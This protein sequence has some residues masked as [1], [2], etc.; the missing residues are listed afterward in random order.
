MGGVEGPKTAYTGRVKRIGLAL[1]ISAVMLITASPASA[2]PEPSLGC[3]PTSDTP[4]RTG[5][6]TP[7]E[8]PLADIILFQPL[9][10]GGIQIFAAT[11]EVNG[12]G[13]T[14][15]PAGVA[16]GSYLVA[17]SARATFTVLGTV[18]IGGCLPTGK[19]QCT[20]G[21]WRAFDFMN[22]G[23]CVAFVNRGAKA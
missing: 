5:I 4:F 8:D 16:P 23:R 21:G 1:V 10:G 12:E 9:P 18:Q 6:S 7:I 22:Q 13:L 14:I 2:Q 3:I 11:D 20:K 17:F 19:D 15:F